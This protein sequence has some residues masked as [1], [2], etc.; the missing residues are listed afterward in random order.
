M[1]ISFE[2]P[3]KVSG[4][5]TI[6]F[7][8]ADYQEEVD[9]QLKNYR[10][11]ANI[12]GFRVGQAPMGMIKRQFGTAVK[13]EVVE[14]LLDEKLTGYIRDNQIQMLGNPL[15]SEAQVPVD[16]EKD[17]NF[18]FKFDIALAPEFKAEL[19]ADDTL[20]FYNITVDDEVVNRQVELFQSRAGSYEKAEV[21]DPEQ[22][23]MLKG[24]LKEL[25][26]N[27]NEKEGGIVVEAAVMMPEYIKVDEQ[28]ALFAEAKPGD[29]ITFNPR[30]AYPE[31]DAEISSLLKVD[32]EAVANINSDFTYLVTEVQR[33]VK[34]PVDQKLFDQIYGEG[35]VTDE[36]DF[37]AKIAEGIKQQLAPQEDYKFM[38]DL[39]KYMEEKVGEL[40]FPKALLQRIMKENSKEEVKNFDE[41][42]ENSIKMLKWNLIEQQLVEANNIKIDDNDVKAVAKNAARAQFAQYGMTNVPED[43]INQYAEN[44]LKDGKAVE[45]MVDRAVDLKLIAALKQVVKL[46][47]KSISLADFDKMMQEK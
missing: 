17:E 22:K 35:N 4:L 13:A 10:K 37:R 40:E 29:V 47:E 16:I 33:F 18:E 36:A 3:E 15:K 6:S 27:G 11:K 1:N 23:D 7:E 30:K 24:D 43:Y 34:A 39:Q 28:K 44:M 5:L 25:D 42:Y 8:K 46:E 45:N 32:K 19:T 21:Y 12:P 31:S 26:E 20:P 2:T 38:L 41:V 9:K 14:R